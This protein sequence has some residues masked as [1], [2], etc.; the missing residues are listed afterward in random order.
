MLGFETFENRNEISCCP[1]RRPPEIRR[2]RADEDHRYDHHQNSED[3]P[4]RI[5]NDSAQGPPPHEP[6]EWNP[7]RH[8]NNQ[9]HDK[10]LKQ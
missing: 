9:H 8:P 1:F 6:P 7:D 5:R 10:Q 2:D 4:F 3:H